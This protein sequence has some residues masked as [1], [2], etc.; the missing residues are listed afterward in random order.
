MFVLW[1][2]HHPTCC[3]GGGD[4]DLQKARLFEP[5]CLEGDST[6]SY[7]GPFRLRPPFASQQGAVNDSMV[8]SLEGV[9]AHIT[10]LIHC[11]VDT[12]LLRAA[13]GYPVEGGMH[14]PRLGMAERRQGHC[15]QKSC[16]LFT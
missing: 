7:P 13:S 12:A 9:S 3:T 4:S 2:V 16:P 14:H 8:C 10:W 6:I 11:M 5:Q 1:S 15:L